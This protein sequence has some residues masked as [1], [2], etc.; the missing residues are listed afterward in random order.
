MA[1]I[2][3]I[4]FWTV[5]MAVAIFLIIDGKSLDYRNHIIPDA[6]TGGGIG[7]ALGYVFSLKRK[8]DSK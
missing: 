8:K 6:L 2:L 5:F 1:R 7:A 3:T 4:L